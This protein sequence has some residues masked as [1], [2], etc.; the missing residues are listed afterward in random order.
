MKFKSYV[1]RDLNIDSLHFLGGKAF[2]TPNLPD[3][4]QTLLTWGHFAKETLP[5][6]GFTFWEW[7]FAILKVTREHLRVLWNDGTIMGFVGKKHAEDLLMAQANGTFILRYSDSEMGGVTIAW[8]AENP[9]TMR[10]EVYNLQPFTSKDFQ[11]RALAD[12]INDLKHLVYLYPN[13]PKDEAFGKYYAQVN[14]NQPLPNGY[15]KP[16]LVV[17][18]PG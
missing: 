4:S 3:Y 13:I 14:E 9:D 6:N 8:V 10:R 16:V 1:G 11:I 12:R 15:V 17:Q 2:R 5:N 7:F 18:I